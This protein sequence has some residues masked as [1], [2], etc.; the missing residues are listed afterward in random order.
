MARPFDAQA[1]EF[2]GEAVAVVEDVATFSND[3]FAAFAVS[4][5]G[6]LIYRKVGVPDTTRSLVWI[7]R[8][9]RVSESI[10]APIQTSTPVVRL[11]PDDR[12]IVFATLADGRPDDI[13][14]HDLQRN[15][16]LRL[17]A[18]QGLDHLPRD[19]FFRFQAEL[20][21]LRSR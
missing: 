4:D 3:E 21:H 11:S 17:T 14:T 10:G 8:N 19:L 16:R 2:T 15:I 6:T 13:W 12:F 7:D 20:P 5:A 9:G 18:D 1:L